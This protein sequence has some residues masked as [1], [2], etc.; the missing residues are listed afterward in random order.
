MGCWNGTCGLS[1]IA[2]TAGTKVKA[3]IIQNKARM[4]EASGFC[5]SSGYA[6]PKTFVIEGIYNDYGSI[7]S[8]VD[9]KAIR[10]FREY[11]NEELKNGNITVDPDDYYDREMFGDGEIDYTKVTHEQFIDLFERDRVNIKTTY[12]SH[13]EG[14]KH[15]TVNLGLMM[16]HGDVYDSVKDSILNCSDWDYKNLKEDIIRQDCSYAVE[17]MFEN[18]KMDRYTQEELD[19]LAEELKMVKEND[20][21]EKQDKIM[22]EIALIIRLSSRSS[23]SWDSEIRK[24]GKWSNAVGI[25]RGSE[26]G[27]MR[28]FNNY[29]G[30]LKADYNPDEKEEIID[31]LAEMI[32]L[33]NM[34]SSLRKPW[35]AQS[36]KGSQSFPDEV[37]MGL[38]KG[39]QKAVY[40]DREDIKGYEL[41]AIKD[42]KQLGS[43]A[44]FKKDSAYECVDT[45]FERD[46][47][48]IKV[49]DELTTIIN[50]NEFNTYFEY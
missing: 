46:L 11:F 5:Y 19:E 2:I 3:V 29:H 22:E 25:F 48:W 10:L 27:N 4:P 12:Y 35:Q 45:D 6:D 39:I 33:I 14:N 34:M 15:A 21:T 20:D 8:V 37:Y 43:G 40:S 28:V 50:W 38:S 7:E 1:Q 16:F 36:G 44:S 47:I 9:N 17:D 41:Y 18:P 24:T 23:G 30:M 42:W 32:Y 49:S 31:M 13:P 26:G